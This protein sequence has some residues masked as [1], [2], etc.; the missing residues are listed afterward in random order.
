MNKLI[1]TLALLASTNVAALS[2]G[3]WTTTFDPG[4][5]IEYTVEDG[6]LSY[7]VIRQGKRQQFANDVEIQSREVFEDVW[8]VHMHI[9]ETSI[10][11]TM[12]LDF[13]NNRSQESGIIQYETEQEFVYF[14]AG[15]LSEVEWD[16]D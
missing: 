11:V 7:Q 12:L 13:V 8:M 10:I 14:W 9:E 4:M 15:E 6:L 16:N 1:A 5:V 2:D 3:S